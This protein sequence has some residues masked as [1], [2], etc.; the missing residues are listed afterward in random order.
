MAQLSSALVASAAGSRARAILGL[1]AAW[2]RAVAHGPALTV[3]GAPGD[4]LALHRAIAEV[5]EGEVIVLDAEGSTDAALCGDLLALAAQVRGAAGL[6][7]NGAVR[8]LAGIEEL[9]FPV[10]SC[11]TSP[12]KPGKELPGELR[13]SLDIQG[14][15]IEMGDLVVADADGIVVVS[16][17]DSDDVLAEAAALETREEDLRRRIEAGES[18]LDLMDLR[19]R[20]R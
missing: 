6:V 20:L 19:E 7:V 15:P 14:V 8:D 11:G 12:L 5:S 17:R 3:R 1:A 10:F 4:N 9:G 18:T 16:A 2:P 13:V